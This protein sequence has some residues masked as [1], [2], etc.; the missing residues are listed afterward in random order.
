MAAGQGWTR[1]AG[2]EAAL[3]EGAILDGVHRARA[4]DELGLECPRQPFTG[5]RD[6][7]L[8]RVISLNL[9]RR[10]LNESQR[11]LIAAEIATMKQ[12]A[13]KGNQNAAKTNGPI[14]PF[15]ESEQRSATEAA[16]VLNV[17]KKSVDRARALKREAPPE[18]VQEVARGEKTEIGEALLRQ[19]SG[20]EKIRCRIFLARS[21]S[22]ARWANLRQ[23]GDMGRG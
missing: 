10:H 14:D 7:A 8:D 4:C 20:L 19:L 11:A 5:T 15:V 21:L 16:K 9:K 12:G 6:E 23:A 2:L 18:V 22:A 13:P 3:F 1:W 17:S